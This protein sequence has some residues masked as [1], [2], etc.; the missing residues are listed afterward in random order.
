MNKKRFVMLALVL[1]LVLNLLAIGAAS[2]VDRQSSAAPIAV[3]ASPGDVLIN[4]FIATPTGSEAVELYN[5]TGSAIDVSGWT[6]DG[7]TIIAGQVVSA[8]D[9][10]VL[11]TANAP[12]LSISNAGEVLELVDMSA[13]TIDQV[14][15]GDDGGAP[16]P[17]F[18][19]STGRAPN[20]MDTDDDAAD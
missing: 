5:T 12:G 11:T 1:V 20:G 7:A 8:T 6:I 3:V 16:K 17:F 18:A 2:A 15:Y 9:Y 19:T 13:T 4:E 14:G 10:L